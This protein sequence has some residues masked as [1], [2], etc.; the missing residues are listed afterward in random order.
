VAGVD[1]TRVAGEPGGAAVGA[2]AGGRASGRVSYRS[3]RHED[4]TLLQRRG[5][6][7]RAKKVVCDDVGR[8]VY[9]DVAMAVSDDVARAYCGFLM[10]WRA[11]SIS[12]WH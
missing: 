6:K 1:P 12:A 9:D 5:F 11:G 3:P 2:S 10:T 4:T 7:M 8:E